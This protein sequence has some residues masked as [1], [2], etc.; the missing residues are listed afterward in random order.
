MS[1]KKI[2][3]NL[4]M[5]FKCISPTGSL[6]C[7]LVYY[8]LLNN[9]ELTQYTLHFKECSIQIFGVKQIFIRAKKGVFNIYNEKVILVHMLYCLCTA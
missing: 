4:Q 8:V 6:M 7:T 2:K 1:N 9:L 5:Y 3:S